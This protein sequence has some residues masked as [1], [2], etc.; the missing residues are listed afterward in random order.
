MDVS[1][2]SQPRPWLSLWCVAWFMIRVH[3]G[4]NK[5]QHRD[6]YASSAEPPLKELPS[7]SSSSER[8]LSAPPSSLLEADTT[9]LRLAFTADTLRGVPLP[10]PAG[11]GD[12]SIG[13]S[14][15]PDPL[16]PAAD[17]V[18]FAA[19]FGFAGAFP[20]GR[21]TNPFRLLWTVTPAACTQLEMR[22]PRYATGMRSG[23]CDMKQHDAV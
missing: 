7:S 23:R 6:I 17:A 16:S 9:S 13:S 18:G 1:T 19:A 20:G 15:S 11:A 12:S 4:T 2:V 22:Q 10:R 14:S 3:V 5:F 21:L 8:S